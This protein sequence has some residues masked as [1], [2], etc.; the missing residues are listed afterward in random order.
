MT[1]LLFRKKADKCIADIAEN[2]WQKIFE[3]ILPKHNFGGFGELPKGR[4]L[5]CISPSALRMW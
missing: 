5:P 4:G 3:L 1:L 2:L